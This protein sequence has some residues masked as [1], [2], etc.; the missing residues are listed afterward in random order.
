MIDMKQEVAI[1]KIG[2]DYFCST[3]LKT[4]GIDYDFVEID[5]IDPMGLAI[6]PLGMQFTFLT[7]EDFY[8]HIEFQT[9]DSEEKDLRRFH[10]YE[11]KFSDRTGKNVI[12][13]VIYFGGTEHAIT[14][15]D[16]GRYSYRVIPIY[17]LAATDADSILKRLQ[18][19]K[20]KGEVFTEED[21]VQLALAPLIKSKKNPKDIILE[22]LEL[23]KMETSTSAEK[24]MAMLYILADKFL[25]DMDSV[26]VKKKI[27]TTRIEQMMFV[28]GVVRGREFA[29]QEQMK[30]MSAL[31]SRLLKEKR[32]DDIQR[33]V[34]DEEYTEQLMKEFNISYES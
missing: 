15:I 24:T 21:F 18:E 23:C 17:Y 20:Q 5:S 34:E 10:V 26:W 28:D 13:Y 2:F 8:I 1:L 22:S 25:M 27:E 3:I 11:S 29:R 19:K 31:V 12:T 4:L 6:Q 33:M 9:M 32:L 14:E 30:L 7:V 16:C